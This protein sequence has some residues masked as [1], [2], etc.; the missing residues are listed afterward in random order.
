MRNENA[1]LVKNNTTGRALDF[2]KGH[3]HWVVVD[4]SSIKVNF[5]IQNYFL[6]KGKALKGLAVGFNFKTSFSTQ[7]PDTPNPH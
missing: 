1:K 2:L 7:G 4:E 6:Y 3:R 5:S